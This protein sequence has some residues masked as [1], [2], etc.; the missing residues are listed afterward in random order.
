MSYLA[1]GL[2][3]GAAFLLLRGRRSR[4]IER[5]VAAR[6]VATVERMASLRPLG[7]EIVAKLP[8]VCEP[9]YFYYCV[10]DAHEIRRVRKDKTA[11]HVAIKQSE[12]VGAMPCARDENSR[13]Y[14]IDN[15]TSELYRRADVPSDSEARHVDQAVLV[16]LVGRHSPAELG[17]IEDQLRAVIER[18]GLGEFDGNEIGATSA[19]LYMYGPDAERLFVGIEATLRGHPLT[20]NSRVEIRRGG[21]GAEQREVRL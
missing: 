20:Q 18:H 10:R 13:L 7:L 6:M 3:L 19:T 16:H 1:I 2:A 21:P 5:L 11:W 8:F 9:G 12:H 4:R 17:A 15:A 14:Y